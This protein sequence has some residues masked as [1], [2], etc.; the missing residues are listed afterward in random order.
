MLADGQGLVQRGGGQIRDLRGDFR[1]FGDLTEIARGNA[2][3]LLALETAQLSLQDFQWRVAGNQTVQFAEHGG[4]VF[5]VI[6][7]VAHEELSQQLR[8]DSQRGGEKGREAQDLYQFPDPSLFKHDG[9]FL[10][11]GKAM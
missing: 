1:N 8:A 3:C 6:Q 4:F 2:Q 5:G 11:A 9:Q 7:S 10:R